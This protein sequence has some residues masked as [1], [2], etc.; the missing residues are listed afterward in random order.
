MEIIVSDEADND[1]MLIFSYLNQ[2]SPQASESIAREVDRCFQNISS[3]P[4]SGSA[5]PDLGHDIKNVLV[6]PYVIF[7]AVRS[8]HITILRVLHGSRNIQA[9]FRR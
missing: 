6:P 9:E 1:L 5:R 8:N 7:Y 4:Y 2:Q 3:F